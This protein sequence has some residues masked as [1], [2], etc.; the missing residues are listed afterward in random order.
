MKTYV[1]YD[2]LLHFEKL[3]DEFEEDALAAAQ[4]DSNAPKRKQAHPARP[5][6][7]PPCEFVT[8]L[9]TQNAKDLD[10]AVDQ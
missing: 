10:A 3:L 8:E 5:D 2:I 1:E 9:A 6:A 4:D 7:R